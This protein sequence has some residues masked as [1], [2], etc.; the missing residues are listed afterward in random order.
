MSAWIEYEDGSYDFTLDL[1]NLVLDAI[2]FAYQDEPLPEHVLRL[3]GMLPDGELRDQVLDVASRFG[4][5]Q[6]TLRRLT[7]QGVS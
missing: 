6:F 5:H 2:A 3:F 7:R 1:A 4:E